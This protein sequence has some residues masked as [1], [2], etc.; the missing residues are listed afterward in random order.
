MLIER[1][2]CCNARIVVVGAS[3]TGISF[4]QTL[5]S[6]RYMNFSNIILLAPGGFTY[7]YLKD[8]IKNLKASSTNFTLAEAEKLLLECRTRVIN[9]R[10]IDIDREKKLVVLHDGHAL[11]YDYLVITAGLTD[12][13]L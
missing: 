12:K 1:K 7:N 13:T 9:A 11:N 5:L 4:I 6:F 2:A 10:M 3:D 8:S